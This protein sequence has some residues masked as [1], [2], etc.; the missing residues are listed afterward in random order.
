MYDKNKQA[1]V[2]RFVERLREKLDQ[3]EPFENTNVKI[4]LSA[5]LRNDNPS[6]R[7][8]FENPIIYVE[9]IFWSNLTIF[10]TA[11]DVDQNEILSCDNLPIENEDEANIYID[12]VLRLL[13][14][15]EIR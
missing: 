8:I 2:N 1:V 13:M 3:L 12:K 7:I 10:V 9:F 11:V 6:V 4:F 5:P 15:S 14:T